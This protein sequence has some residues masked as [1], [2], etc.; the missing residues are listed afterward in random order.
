MMNRITKYTTVLLAVLL[1]NTAMAAG[2]EK[3]EEFMFQSGKIY[4]FAAVS[5]IILVGIILYLV[6][7]DRKIG[8]ME[9]EISKE[10][11]S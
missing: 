1:T 11:R 4:V 7:L 8:R 6:S 9:K 2:K 3:M 5:L 10:N